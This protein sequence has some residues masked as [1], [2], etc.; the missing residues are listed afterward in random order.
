MVTGPRSPGPVAGRR[1]LRADS[2]LC[3]RSRIYLLIVPILLVLVLAFPGCGTVRPVPGEIVRSFTPHGAYGGHWGVDLA[4]EE[5]SVV[6]AVA[7]GVVT[8]AGSVAG[9]LS[10][11]IHHGGGVRTSY[12]YLS[13]IGAAPG[14]AV[15]AGQAIARSGLDR[16]AA[17]VHLSLRMSDRYLDPIPWLACALGDP[18]DGVRL[19]PAHAADSRERIAAGEWRGGAGRSHLGGSTRPV[20]LFA[21]R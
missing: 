3:V 4:A 18:A 5:G 7:G 20:V 11:T 16:G 21:D 10:I 2:L 12:S 14:Q 1:L 15:A 8:F 19:V 9:R 17:A 6:R 13:A